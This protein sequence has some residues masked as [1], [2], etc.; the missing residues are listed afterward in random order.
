M[1]ELAG[2]ARASER[3]PLPP[4][5]AA[6]ESLHADRMLPGHQVDAAARSGYAV[7]SAI[8]QDLL[9][10]DIKLAAIVRGE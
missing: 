10:I 6:V 2:N 3:R 7:I 8:A 1:V 4:A 9:P 5:T